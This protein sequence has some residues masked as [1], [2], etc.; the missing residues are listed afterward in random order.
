MSRI[1]IICPKSAISLWA[2]QLK[3]TFSLFCFTVLL[4]IKRGRGLGRNWRQQQTQYRAS[5]V[6]SQHEK[7]GPLSL[8]PTLSCAPAPRNQPHPRSQDSS[9]VGILG[10]HAYPWWGRGKY[11]QTGLRKGGVHWGDILCFAEVISWM[12]VTISKQWMASTWPNSATMR[13]SACWRMSGKEWFL[14]LS[15]SCRQS[16]SHHKPGAEQLHHV[17]A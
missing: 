6:C 7:R 10:L 5:E 14:K 4:K 16:V 8:S 3:I 2:E 17:L 15:M 1:W 13:S 12:W 11:G 9:C